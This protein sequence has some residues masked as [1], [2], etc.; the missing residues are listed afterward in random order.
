MARTR[1]DIVKVGDLEDGDVFAT[2]TTRRIG[3]F[4]RRGRS[5]GSA[6]IYSA[7][8]YLDPIA[9][10]TECE[11]KRLHLDIK[12]E[13]LEHEPF[14]SA[15]NACRE[16]LRH[17]QPEGE[18]AV[19]AVLLNGGVGAGRSIFGRLY[20][21]DHRAFSLPLSELE[22]IPVPGHPYGARHHDVA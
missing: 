21:R 19:D 9:G 22:E 14:D 6:D 2:L 18:E 13:F 4:L 15:A 3:T 8:V 12:V 7:E 10:Q 17:L 5:A 1:G 20:R 16:P 11:E